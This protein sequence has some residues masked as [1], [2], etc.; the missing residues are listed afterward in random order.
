MSRAEQLA[1]EASKSGRGE[2]VHRRAGVA[3]RGVKRA[4]ARR[5]VVVC[6]VGGK[7]RCCGGS[8]V[9][10]SSNPGNV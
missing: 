10:W 3:R 9:S 4:G 6:L 1:P 8:M 2:R 5:A 7:G